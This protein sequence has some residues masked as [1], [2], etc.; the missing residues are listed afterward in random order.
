MH[1]ENDLVDPKGVF[2]P[3]GA[4]AHL[5]QTHA[6]ENVQKALAAARDKGLRVIHIRVAWRLVH[7]AV[8]GNVPFFA[9]VVQGGAL[10]AGTWG[11]EFLPAIA[12]NEGEVV[13]VTRGV[14]AF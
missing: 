14:R 8:N 11:A 3:M 6:V 5:E 7:P 10:V 12:P 1:F 9:G 4:A 13:I 2:A